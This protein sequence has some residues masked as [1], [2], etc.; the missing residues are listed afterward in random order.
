[1]IFS[2]HDEILFPLCSFHYQCSKTTT[3]HWSLSRV[4]SG[5]MDEGHFAQLQWRGNG[6][7]I[8]RIFLCQRT[9]S[10]WKTFHKSIV[11]LKDRRY[12]LPDQSDQLHRDEVGGL[13]ACRG[14]IWTPGRIGSIDLHELLR[15][16]GERIHVL[17]TQ[18][19]A[20]KSRSNH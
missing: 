13:D 4:W 3:N 8:Y 16:P 1:M 7:T 14:Y 11:Q 10:T 9:M 15:F 18:L 20:K 19:K 5:R 17:F 6:C 12:D 2:Y